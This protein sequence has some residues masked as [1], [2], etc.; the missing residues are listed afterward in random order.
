MSVDRPSRKRAWQVLVTPAHRGTSWATLTGRHEAAVVLVIDPEAEEASVSEVLQALYGLTPAETRVAV[1]IGRGQGLIATADELG[2]CLSTAR[3][4]LR[5]VF[6]K[7]D[8]RRQ[9]EL[10]RLL[11]RITLLR[12]HQNA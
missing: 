2:V 12:H 11:D 3:T 6:V 9:A 5:Q 7:T 8:T 4:H 10:V 1:T